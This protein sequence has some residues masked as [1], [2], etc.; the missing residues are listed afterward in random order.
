MSAQGGAFTLRSGRAV[1]CAHRADELLP[2]AGVLQKAAYELQRVTWS[3]SVGEQDGTSDVVV[4]FDEAIAPQAYRLRVGENSITLTG[5]DLAGVHHGVMT[6]RQIFRQGQGA[7]PSVLIEDGPDFV[8]RG[9]MLDISRDKVPK[10]GTLFE[11]V[12]MLS[13]WK[14]NRLELYMEHTFAYRNH[15]EVWAE[16]SPMTGED[17]LRLDC[18]CKE[19]FVELV[20]NQN[21]FGHLHRWLRLP[22]YQHLAECPQGSITPRGIALPPYSLDPKNDECLTFL[23]ELYGE[24]LPHF[25]SRNFNVG[26]DETFDLGQGKSK[27][28]CQQEGLGRVYLDFLLKVHK[29]V[30]RHGRRM[31]FWGDIIINHPELIDELPQDATALEWGYEADHPFD[32]HLEL[33]AGSG[34][35]FFVCPGTSSWNSIAGRTQNCLANIERAVSSG[36][37]HGADGMLTTDWG[38]LGHWQYLPVSFL[39]LA[40][41]AALSWCYESNRNRDLVPALD[42]HA[43]YDRAGV[44]GRVAHDLGNAYLLAGGRPPNS[45]SL[46]HILR[47]PDRDSLPEGVSKQSLKD[48]WQYIISAIERLQDARLTRRDADLIQREFSN[49]ARLLLFA[50]KR[51]SA[52]LGNDSSSETRW[53]MATDLRRILGRHREL[54]VSRNRIGGLSDSSWQLEAHLDELM[55]YQRDRVKFSHMS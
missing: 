30:Q 50:C 27:E 29:L 40:A 20:P 15:P 46:F 42:V 10:L 22:R 5:G 36:L 54:W 1:V 41:G 26:C 52:L 44:M 39:G 3:I 13:E 51:G 19:R 55:G 6:L 32:E 2:V 4:A 35:P 7:I 23:D 16:A 33:F 24:L 37:R 25:T 11:L 12:D 47:A 8:S 48:C 43:F 17:I 18:Y 9:V 53:Q 21:S 45:S 34:V 38:D 28:A 14:I 49:A 31:H